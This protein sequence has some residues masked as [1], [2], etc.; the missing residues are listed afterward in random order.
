M[1]RRW[2]IGLVA[3]GAIVI[4]AAGANASET[5]TYGYDA[6]G[7]LVSSVRSGGPNAGIVV[8]TCFDQAGNR[9]RNDT[10]TSVSAPC[11]TPS[12]TPTPTP[13]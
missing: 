13:Y 3:S 9:M 8:A 2:V 11:P 7:R 5:V 12:A 6:L 10:T 1:R 4:L